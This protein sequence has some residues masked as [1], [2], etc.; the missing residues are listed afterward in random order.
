MDHSCIVE[1]R[2]PL[3]FLNQINHTLRAAG[4]DTTLI[5]G[6]TALML[7]ESCVLGMVALTG[8]LCGASFAV[9]GPLRLAWSQR[10]GG[11]AGS[12]VGADHAGA[13]LGALLCATLLVPVFGTLQAALML[14]GLKFATALL[15]AAGPRLARR[16]ALEVK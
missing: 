8:L 3:K 2:Q 7:V 11:A 4:A 5:T 1:S 13:C 12:V 9:A 16:P 10:S 6:P 15:V 14:A